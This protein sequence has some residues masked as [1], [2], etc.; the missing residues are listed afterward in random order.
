MTTEIL[1]KINLNWEV[2]QKPLFGP[3]GERT[4]FFGQFRSDNDTCLGVSTE[5]YEISQNYEIV[6]LLVNYF[7]SNLKIENVEGNSI[8]SGRKIY[9]TLKQDNLFSRTTAELEQKLIIKNSHDGSS[10]LTFGFMD[11]VLICS[12]GMVRWVE[13]K[14]KVR[15]SHTS[16]LRT[17]LDNFEVLY[18]EF[19]QFNEL[20]KNQYEQFMSTPVTMSLAMDMLDYINKC[21]TSVDNFQE[22]YSARKLNILE[23][24]L[25][26]IEL[27]ISRQGLNK[28]GLLQGITN[29]TT[30]HLGNKKTPSERQESLLIGNGY[31]Y[32]N[33]ALN[34]LQNV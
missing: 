9:V 7:G 29:F 31:K 19:L 16:S 1:N 15:I 8:Q 14:Q 20:K 10:P 4:R 25:E 28:F 18:S 34:F 13:S 26:S 2:N 27:E 17:K 6:D 11:K 23:K 30:H 3:E 32:N 33:M 21:D 12:N 24:Q 5:K 22:V